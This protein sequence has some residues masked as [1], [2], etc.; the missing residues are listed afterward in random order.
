MA[1]INQSQENRFEVCR[2]EQRIGRVHLETQIVGKTVGDS[3]LFP[4]LHRV[5][6]YEKSPSFAKHLTFPERLLNPE[7]P[8]KDYDYELLTPKHPLFETL[9][10]YISQIQEGLA[11]PGL[12]SIASPLRKIQT[13]YQRYIQDCCMSGGKQ[14][15]SLFKG[16]AR[17]SGYLQGEAVCKEVE[18][19]TARCLVSINR[20]NE[21]VRSNAFGSSAV[22]RDE[23]GDVFYKRARFNPLRPGKEYLFDAF[24]TFFLGGRASPTKLFKID[25][26][27]V[28]DFLGEK[29][30]SHPLS[31]RLYF[32]WLE[33]KKNH[34]NLL[35][36]EFIHDHPEAS[37]HPFEESRKGFFV[38]ASLGVQGEELNTYLENH[39]IHDFEQC[40]SPYNYGAMA[41]LSLILR[42][43]D[44]R[45]DNY[46][47]EA[48]KEGHREI[49]GIDNDGILLPPIHK[50]RSGQHI[51]Q[52]R[53]ILFLLKDLMNAPLDEG[54]K[55]HL[56]SLNIEKTFISYLRELEKYSEASR[57]Q[58]LS[59]KEL[60]HLDLPLKL[61]LQNLLSI[62]RSMKTI[63][64]TLK[65][66]ENQ[67]IA[68][69]FKTLYPLVFQT[70]QKLLENPEKSPL[71]IQYLLFKP[72]EN[73]SIESLLN[74]SSKE[75]EESLKD[76]PG[77]A[78]KEASP[79]IA[80]LLDPFIDATVPS[81]D[82]KEQE[83]LLTHAHHTFKTFKKTS[84]KEIKLSDP[85]LADMIEREGIQ[86]L[87][88]EDAHAITSEGIATI[89]SDFPSVRI[90]IGKNKTFTPSSLAAL[91]QTAQKMQRPLFY[92]IRE[93][94]YALSNKD[95]G[96]LLKPAITNGHLVL[97]E[98]LCKN[99]PV[100][101]MQADR[102]GNNLLHQMAKRGTP[103]IIR[104]LI[105]TIGLPI[106]IPNALGQTPFHLAAEGNNVKALETLLHLE[107][108]NKT[109]LS[110][111]DKS[112][113]TPFQHAS[114]SLATDSMRFLLHEILTHRLPAGQEVHLE[115]DPEGYT[116]LHMAAKFGL[117]EEIPPLLD[118]Y[119]IPV[120]ALGALD[121]TPLHMA[122]HN[123]QVEA[124]QILLERGADINARSGEGDGLA[125]PLHEGVF[126]NKVAVI[127]LLVQSEDL[128]INV[129]NAR[130]FSPVDL[131][132]MTG[133]LPIARLLITDP[134][135]QNKEQK[136]DDY[137]N[138]ATK[139]RFLH[140][141]PFLYTEKSILLLEKQP[142]QDRAQETQRLITR[143]E[144][145]LN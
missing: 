5:R 74:L 2:R 44:G 110:Q 33:Q 89:L 82:E 58:G 34:P 122:A 59:E 30:S 66:D 17:L 72:K 31:Q 39:S 92:R 62:Y 65:Q 24:N 85:A 95:L 134:R 132:V 13:A 73:P 15:R 69:L 64:E 47:L 117:D 86:E 76:L 104:F 97:A 11:N 28:K 120:D 131:A 116:L 55:T 77:M 118:K 136:L 133:S 145:T 126:Q 119:N 7:K 1:A 87:F 94:D 137:I 8:L 135:F 106:T 67:S 121:R 61:S 123:G 99:S 142:P 51:I 102:E 37:S 129:Q 26:I 52:L 20:F 46:M 113:R 21:L 41:L 29:A 96:S 90:I 91:I 111:K 42:V 140:L 57:S 79:S 125:T 127:E 49:V 63:Q 38:Q 56:L 6:S 88:L 71:D 53:S 4:D 54:L 141:L 105:E 138:E 43:D 103:P 124:A 48:P 114:Y 139:Y 84:L 75:V 101:L 45:A 93:K 14:R 19:K 107:G 130:G 70:Y 18:R 112:G 108:E 115:K 36:S 60:A 81:L 32:E 9:H 22:Y 10:F 35:Y 143:L 50:T 80:E 100:N 144:T 68:S 3:V 78:L 40:I 109:A 12:Q 16:P 83:E 27:T 25:N 98:A 23:G 128:D